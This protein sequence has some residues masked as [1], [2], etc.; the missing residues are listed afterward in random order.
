MLPYSVVREAPDPEGTLLAFL[1]RTYGAAADLG[2][3]DR[4]LLDCAR[5]EALKPREPGCIERADI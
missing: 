4:A 1:D 3:W 5:G 2:T